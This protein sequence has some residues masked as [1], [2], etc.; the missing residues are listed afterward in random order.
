[1]PAHEHILNPEQIKVLTAWVWGLSNKSGAGASGAA[2][3][4]AAA[5]GTATATAAPVAVNAEANAVAK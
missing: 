3:S 1:M 5:S 4:G 2:A